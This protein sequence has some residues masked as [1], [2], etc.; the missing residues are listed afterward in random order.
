VARDR[1]AAAERALPDLVTR[2]DVRGD[3]QMHTTWSDGRASVREMAEAAQAL[4]HEYIL[5]TDHG[6]SLHVAGGPDEEE[7]REQAKEV[8]AANEALDI[9]VLHGAEANVTGGGLDVSAE[10]CRDLD[11]VVASLHDPVDDATERL[12][13][14]IEAYPVDFVGH[15]TNRLIHQ[16]EGNDL[17]LDRLL[18]A[19]SAHDV[20][21]EINA[22]PDRMDLPWEAVQRLRSDVLFSIGTDAHSTGDLEHVGLGV[23]QARKG[24]LTAEDV[25]NT[26]PADE[27]LSTLRG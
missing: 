1:E 22:Q 14:A 12:V 21:L 6:P 9:R 17:D 20:A 15:P 2:E 11:L 4:G 27:L 10:A 5:I 8:Q 18:E 19:A 16:R 24:W 26:L 23:D 13:Q 7:L 25:V 3:L